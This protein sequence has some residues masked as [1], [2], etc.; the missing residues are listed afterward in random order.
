MSVPPA[1]DI[2][3]I[4]CATDGSD[5]SRAAAQRA[6]A[7]ARCA[8]AR[9]VGLYVVDTRAA[10]RLGIHYADAVGEMEAEGQRAL[11]D[12]GDLATASGVTFTPILA[13]GHP[14]QE[15][16]NVAAAQG[17]DL[18]VVGAHGRSALERALLGSVSEHVVRHAPCDVLVV[19]RPSP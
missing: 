13:G 7:L 10:V 3:L 6:V 9:L 5:C 2:R 17:A 1:L 16:L 12:M 14:K 8:G 4:V 15:I 18:I 19:R 11:A